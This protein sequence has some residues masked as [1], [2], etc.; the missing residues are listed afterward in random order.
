MEAQQAGSV[1]QAA[2]FRVHPS[3]ERFPGLPVEGVLCQKV[4]WLPVGLWTGA[5]EGRFQALGA[6][7]DHVVLFHWREG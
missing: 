7:R 2:P 3:P 4:G 5:Q 1:V 6:G